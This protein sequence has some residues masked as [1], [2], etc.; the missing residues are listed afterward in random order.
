M[1]P[2][3]SANSQASG[4]YPTREANLPK[5]CLVST[6]GGHQAQLTRLE[7]ILQ[8]FPSY[9]VSVDSPDTTWNFPG[10]RKYPVQRILRNPA[11]LALNWIQSLAILVRERPDAIITTGAGDALPTVIIGAML[12]I[13]IL[14]IESV[15]RVENPS[16]FGLL[17]HRFA[18][19]TVIQWPRLRRW[20]PEA[21]LAMPLMMPVSTETKIP[22]SPSIVVLT[23]THTRGFERL[24]KAID[25][26]LEDGRLEAQVF[27]QIGH[28]AYSPLRY[29][30]ERFLPH[31]VLMD[32]LRAADVVVTHDGSGSIADGLT[33]GKPVLVVPR[34]TKA[35]E[36]SYRSTSELARHLSS[37][38]WITLVEDPLE[39][40]KA[41]HDL[42]TKRPIPIGENLPPLADVVRG[43][44][45][46]LRTAE[47][48][49]PLHTDAGDNLSFRR[50]DKGR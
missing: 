17:A 23:G 18:S 50:G 48:A 11:G 1:T 16:M 3:R 47:E 5:L 6:S 42:N 29:A 12:G 44:L 35:S 45:R 27:A 10:I 41:L 8:D 28:S 7:G 19:T 13:P 39:L 31:E 4:L 40:P 33:A 2:R 43:F 36:V 9:L 49:E 34:T 20:Y 38:G 30:Y 15:A 24:L 26:L 25:S 32:R 37:L 14:F 22:R 46:S 21:V